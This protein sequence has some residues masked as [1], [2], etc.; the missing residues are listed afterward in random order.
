MPPIIQLKNIKKKFGKRIVLDGVNLEINDKEIFGIIGMSGSGKSTILKTLVGYYEPELGDLLFYSYK[1]K[2][3]K[4][5]IKHL[6]EVRK[7]FGFSAQTSSFYPKLTVEENLL[8]FGALYKLPYKITKINTERLLKTTELF[9]ARKQL[10]ETLSGGMEKRLSI[11]CSLIHN[12]KILI[13]DEPTADLDPIRRKETWKLIN[14]L[15][16]AGKTIIIA[17]H[18][19]SELELVCTRVALLHQQKIIAVGT[20][21]QLKKKYKKNSLESVFESIQKR[22]SSK[23]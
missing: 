23:K 10:A 11:A 20:P 2:R 1:D 18:F 8:H 21:S 6:I 3:Y 14:W 7:T 9:D 4:P 13:L 15:H 12:P 19:I 17:S 5:I 16:K 22:H